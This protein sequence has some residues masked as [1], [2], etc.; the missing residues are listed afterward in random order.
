MVRADEKMLM[1][2]KNWNIGVMVV[3]GVLRSY[4]MKTD[5]FS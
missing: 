4:D 1:R 5:T 2:A 3:Q